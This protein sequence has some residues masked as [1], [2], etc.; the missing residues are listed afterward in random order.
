[1]FYYLNLKDKKISASIILIKI[2]N[3]FFT[4][5]QKTQL[6]VKEKQRKVAKN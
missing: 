5:F 2:L 6:Q 1:M 3:N 4:K